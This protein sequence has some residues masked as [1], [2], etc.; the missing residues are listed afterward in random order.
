M[1]SHAVD[2]TGRLSESDLALIEA[3]QRDPRAPW[4]Q[5]AAAIGTSAPTARRR[6]ERLV[7]EGSAWITSYPGMRAGLVAGL[8]E[9][10]C[11][12]GTSDDVAAE[13]AT[14]PRIVTVSA[15]TG[16]RDLGLI[17]FADD[18]SE[19][20]RILQHDL[21]AH[22]D[23]VG[24][25]SSIMTRVFR[26]GSHWRAGVL[27][28]A[29]REGDA[30]AERAPA[31]AAPPLTDPATLRVLRELELDGRAPTARIAERLGTGEAHARRTVR[32]LL[33]TRRIVQRV[34]VTLDQPHWPHSLAL[35][36]VVPAAQ[37]DEAARR[38]G[39]LPST[40][41]C[42]ALA[43]G[44]SNLYA[45]VW[46]RSLEEAAE[47]EARITR[48]LPARVLDRSLL[49][50]YYKRLGHRFDDDR[51]RVGQVPWTGP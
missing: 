8:V 2:A 25:R 22:A 31:Q 35:W 6:W 12:P 19:L 17:V 13:L 37:L 51:R 3:L 5:I 29:E 49:L 33:E 40:R 15:Q 41:L 48:G 11:R 4:A 36:M 46:L 34:D 30:E 23:V 20:R 47:I 39:E 16:D 24:V 26:E 21:G 27:G 1:D 28:G 38:I 7:A 10:R 50:H 32:R 44:A 43:G 18:L 45:I 14:H 9:V 42:A